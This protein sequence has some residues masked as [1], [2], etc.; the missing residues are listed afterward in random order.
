MWKEN[1][2][3]LSALINLISVILSVDRTEAEHKDSE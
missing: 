1:E 3:L 2:L